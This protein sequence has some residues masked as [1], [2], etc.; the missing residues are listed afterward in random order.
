LGTYD[1]DKDVVDL[2]KEPII[3]Y[4]ESQVTGDSIHIELRKRRLDRVF[5]YGD[6]FA[7]SQSDSVHVNR[8]DQLTSQKMTLYFLN[9]KLEHIDAEGTAVS[10]YFLYDEGEPNGVNKVS[11]DRVL[12]SGQGGRAESIKV[13]GGTEGQYF[14][15]KSVNGSESKYDLPGF[16]WRA[17]R[18]RLERGLRIVSSPVENEES[19]RIGR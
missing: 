1:P 19:A 5:V 13:Q 3:W 15:E 4:E 16:K 11:G 2:Q 9:D 10:L 12:V 7:V 6:A 14:P 17:D 18:P 8:F